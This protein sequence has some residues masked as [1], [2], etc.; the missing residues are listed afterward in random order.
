MFNDGTSKRIDQSAQPAGMPA[1]A[2]ARGGRSNDPGIQALLD[3]HD[4]LCELEPDVAERAALLGITPEVDAAWREG[5]MLPVLRARGSAMRKA[6]AS[7]EYD[8]G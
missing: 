7:L 6:V 3:V 1:G 8:A 2:G 5:R 4:R